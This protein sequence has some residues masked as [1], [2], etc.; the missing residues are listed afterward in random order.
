[1]P[2]NPLTDVLPVRARRYLYAAYIAVGVVLGALEV[3]RVTAIRGV[4]LATLGDVYRYI[5]TAVVALA[6][7]NLTTSA[8]PPTI[9]GKAVK[10]ALLRYNRQR[11]DRGAT[12]VR[13]SAVILIISVTVWLIAWSAAVVVEARAAEPCGI[14]E[15]Q[16]TV[17]ED[18]IPP[19]P[20]CAPRTGCWKP[21]PGC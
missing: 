21:P 2:T 8:G 10:A 1:M 13:R 9:D 16:P 11:G 18:C 17:P 12:S 14:V 19:E 15:C 4:E 6:V 7:S 3:A 5:G 20:L